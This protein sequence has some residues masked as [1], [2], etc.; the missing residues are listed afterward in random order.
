MSEPALFISQDKACSIGQGLVRYGYATEWYIKRCY[1]RGNMLGY[2]LYTK[3][4]GDQFFKLLR[5]L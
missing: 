3:A 4:K 5:G 2:S 1:D